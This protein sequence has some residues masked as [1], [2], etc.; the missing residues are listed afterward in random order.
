M[1]RIYQGGESISQTP[2][3]TLPNPAVVTV[4]SMRISTGTCDING[5]GFDDVILGANTKAYVYFGHQNGELISIRLLTVSMIL[6]SGWGLGICADANGDNLI[7]LAIVR[8]VSGG[9]WRIRY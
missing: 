1:W 5:D 7:D 4:L 6:G 3:L 2:T 8:T 9:S